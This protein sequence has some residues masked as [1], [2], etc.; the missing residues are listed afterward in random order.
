[1]ATY[2]DANQ[3]NWTDWLPYVTYAYN[4]SHHSSTTF[5]PVYLMFMREPVISLDLLGDADV[6][7]GHERSQEEY[8][9]LMRQRM[10]AAYELVHVNLNRHFERSK[11]RFDIRVRACR[12]KVGEKVWFYSPRKYRYLSPK[13]TLQ[14]TG[15]YDIIRKVNDVNYVIRQPGKRR[16]F[17]VHVDRL[18]SYKL[19][20]SDVTGGTAQHTL[21]RRSLARAECTPLPS[22]RPNR[23]RRIPRRYET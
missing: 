3:K 22:M 14:T 2:V 10:R 12:C 21:H 20:V 5:T 13:W 8:V 15:P 17:T 1:L 11:R 23:T 4:T 16:S 19:P 6:T 9:M 18:R 7:L